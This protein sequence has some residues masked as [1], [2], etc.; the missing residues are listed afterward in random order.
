MV[1]LY[2][3][4]YPEVGARCPTGK[5]RGGRAGA[6][7]FAQRIESQDWELARVRTILTEVTGQVHDA[8]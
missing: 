3:N 6:G 5:G 4:C 2:E 1:E 8:S 7:E